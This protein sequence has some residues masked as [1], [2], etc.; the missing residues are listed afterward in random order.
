VVGVRGFDEVTAGVQPQ[1]ADLVSARVL[2]QAVKEPGAKPPA[3][4]RRNH[5]DAGD[6]GDMIGQQAQPGAPQH[7]S[8]L[9]GHQQQAA[10]G[11]RSSLGSSLMA[12]A[13]SSAVAGRP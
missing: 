13:I 9:R 3:A 4:A 10:G 11:T 1:R 2:F 6:L 7:V 8:V 12:A 5:E